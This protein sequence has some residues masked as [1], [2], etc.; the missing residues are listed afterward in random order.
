MKVMRRTFVLAEQPTRTSSAVCHHLPLVVTWDSGL[1]QLWG[2]LMRAAAA[3]E[4]S[5]SQAYLLHI[6]EINRADLSK[7]LGEAVFLL[8][9]AWIGGGT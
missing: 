9:G 4:K 5:K 1:N 3:A 7:V 2:E 8:E 6:D